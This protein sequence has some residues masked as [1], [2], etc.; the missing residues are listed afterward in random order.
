MSKW[1]TSPKSWRD[2][3]PNS[4]RDQSW[5]LRRKSSA[6]LR[7]KRWQIVDCRSHTRLCTTASINA[8]SPR[9]VI[10]R[11]GKRNGRVGKR[12]RTTPS[13]TWTTTWTSSLPTL[14]R[15]AETSTS[16]LMFTRPTSMCGQSLN[17]TTRRPSSRAN[18]WSRR[19][20]GLIMS[21]RAMGLKWWRPTWANT[22]SS[23]R[24]SLRTT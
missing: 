3:S 15:T 8:D 14:N 24:M 5:R 10:R 6:S 23:W 1:Y 12:L 22:S 7:V 21:W 9:Q 4:R 17:A 20:W 19:R 16:P 18:Q 13:R 11:I 2:A